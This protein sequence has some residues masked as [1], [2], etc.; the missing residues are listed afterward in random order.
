MKLT[1]D[2]Y[3]T[4][5]SPC[6]GIFKDKGSKFISFAYPISNEEEIKPIITDLKKQFYDARHHCFAFRIGYQGEHFRAND[7]GE[8]SSTAGKPILGQ[9]LSNDITNIMVVVVRYFGGTKLGVPGLI[10]AYKNATIDALEN[11]TII[12][13][14]IDIHFN[15]TFDYIVM[16]DVMKIIKDL[17]PNI[18]NQDFELVCNMQL[19]IRKS[20]S[21]QLREKLLKVT[22]LTIND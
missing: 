8:P 11:A 9:L 19:S 16:N 6:E 20:E 4:I 2:T 3:K 17:S 22:S 13:K 21:E 10:N 15:I 7:D 5:E 1:D 18:I 12:E 14:T